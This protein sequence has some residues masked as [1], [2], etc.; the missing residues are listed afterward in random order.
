M[1]QLLGFDPAQR[2]FDPLLFLGI[3]NIK[4]EE[5]DLVF[6]CNLGFRILG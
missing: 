5:K 3:T 2:G 6:Y 4:S 1:Q